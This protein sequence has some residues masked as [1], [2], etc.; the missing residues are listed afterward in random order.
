MIRS[1][2][3]AAFAALLLAT[4]AGADPAAQTAP[5]TPTSPVVTPTPA[6]ASPRIGWANIGVYDVRIDVGG[7]FTASEADFGLGAGGAMDVMALTP[8]VPLSI[9]GN[10]ALSFANGGQF[11]PITAGAAV[12]YNKL[13]VQLLGGLGLTIMPNTYA[14]AS[15][16]VGVGLLLMGILPLPQVSPTFGVQAQFQY[17][18]LSQSESMVEFVGGVSYGF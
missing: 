17:H 2:I 11:I 1:V 4:A 7:G 12:R 10:I 16:A 15:T 13:P 5:T 8:D 9:F 3:P 14:G 18:L 6:P